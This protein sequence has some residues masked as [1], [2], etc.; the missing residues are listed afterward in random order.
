MNRRYCA[1]I[2]DSILMENHRV[3]KN[4]IIALPLNLH[5]DGKYKAPESIKHLKDKNKNE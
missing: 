3:I 4:S 2:H 1:F 5:D